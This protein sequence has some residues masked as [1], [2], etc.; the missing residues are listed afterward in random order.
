MAPIV[1]QQCHLV[2]STCKD[3]CTN[4]EKWGCPDVHTERLPYENL[5]RFYRT[6]YVD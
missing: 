1:D 4:K 2:D 5:R 6:V 3:T